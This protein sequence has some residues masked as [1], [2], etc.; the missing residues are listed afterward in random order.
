MANIFETKQAIDNG[1]R[2]LEA[3][4][5]KGFSTVSH[6]LINFDPQTA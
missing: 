6:N 3:T 4:S 1:G 2:A 5:Y